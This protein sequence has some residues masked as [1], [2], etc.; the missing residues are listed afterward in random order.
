MTWLYGNRS[1]N[2]E[3]VVRTQNP[4]LNTLR[5]IISRPEAL[6]ALRSGYSLERSLAVAIGD[7]RRFRESLT[8]A[9]VELQ[10]AKGTVTTGYSGEDDLYAMVIDITEYADSI[11]DDMDKKRAQ[12]S[13]LQ[14]KN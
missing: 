5:T 13:R 10:N 6:A 8:S 7:K 2:I 1:K 12:Q 3:P 4:D 14:R 11:R 9:K